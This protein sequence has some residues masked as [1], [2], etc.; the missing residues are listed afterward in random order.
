LGDDIMAYVQCEAQAIAAECVADAMSKV[1]ERGPVTINWTVND[2]PFAT[3]E[4]THHKALPRLLK[5]YR[6]GFRNFMI[7]GPAGSG[8]T[9]LAHDLATALKTAFGSVACTAGMSESALTGRS[10]PNLTTGGTEYQSTE[11]V[12]IYEG[13]GVFLLDENDAADANVMLVI[14]SALSNGHIPLPNRID[15]PQATRHADSVVICACNTWGNGSDRQYVGR[16]QLD[17]AYLDRFVGATLAVDYDRDM[18]AALVGDANICATV[19]AIRDKCAALKLRRIV[20]T[21]FL[22]SVAI[23]HKRAGETL[24]DAIAACCEGWTADELTKAGVS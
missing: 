19:W 1:A 7:V 23:L 15:A 4:G 6:A 14:N 5:L 24:K 9:T 12:R 3:V 18:E 11:F 16:N 21:R 8:K 10:I 17:A 13:G 22:L 2:A 20:G